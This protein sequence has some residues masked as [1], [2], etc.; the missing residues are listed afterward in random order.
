M[1]DV[2]PDRKSD[3]TRTRTSIPK[4][5]VTGNESAKFQSRISQF[6]KP[7]KRFGRNIVISL[8]IKIKKPEIHSVGIG[9][10]SEKCA[11]RKLSRN[12]LGRY[13]VYL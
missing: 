9:C 2:V 6:L 1:G 7:V 10:I 8:N 12:T 13:R 5:L 3:Q 4:I 11:V